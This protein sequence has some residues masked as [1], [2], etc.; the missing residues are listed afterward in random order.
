MLL[1]DT[2]PIEIDGVTYRINCTIGEGAAG[3]VYHASNDF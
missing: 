1:H 3:I 2:D